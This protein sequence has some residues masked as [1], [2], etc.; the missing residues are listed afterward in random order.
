MCRGV[1]TL[2]DAAGDRRS[3]RNGKWGNCVRERTGVDMAD[4]RK[5]F[6]T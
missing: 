3:D 4:S 1:S 2:A 5:S 6:G